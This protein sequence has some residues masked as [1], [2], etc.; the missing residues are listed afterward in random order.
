MPMVAGRKNHERIRLAG[1][2]RFRYFLI[3]ISALPPNRQ[4][5]EIAELVLFG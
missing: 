1:E 4:S 2:R 3:W 5:A